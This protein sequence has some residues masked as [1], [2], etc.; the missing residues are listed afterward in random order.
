MRAI[1]FRFADNHGSCS[2]PPMLCPLPYFV[3]VHDGVKVFFTFGQEHR[4]FCRV[5]VTDAIATDLD[6]LDISDLS[7]DVLSV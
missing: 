1:S 3:Y 4:V 6:A 7:K 2:F 5:E